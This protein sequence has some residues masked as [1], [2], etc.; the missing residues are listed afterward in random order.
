MTYLNS[1]L[2]STGTTIFS[3]MS[4]L[5][6]EHN[7]VNLSQGFPDFPVDPLL[8]E[9][10]YKASKDGFNQY[11]PMPGIKSLREGISNVIS[12]IYAVYKNPVTEI[13]IT[14][15]ATEALFA[16]VS[17]AVNR[18]DEVIIFD[19]AYDS[20][21]P[22]VI[23]NG[24][25][26][27]RIPLTFP[28]FKM[29][30][31]KILSAVNKKTK[32]II[33]NSPNNPA[34][35]VISQSD[36]LFIKEIVLKNDLYILSDEV[37]EHIVF[38]GLKHHSVLEDD[39]L[40]KRSFA[41]SS[42]GKTFHITGW[43]VGYCVAPEELTSEFRKIHQYLTFSTSTPF[44]IAL[45]QYITDISRIRSLKNFYSEKRDYFRSLLT[46]NG[47]KPF[48][49]EATY[50]QLLDYSGI[51]DEY[52]F[53]FAVSLTKDFGVA[54]IPLSV[55]YKNKT[56]NKVLRFCFAKEN[57]TLEKAVSALGKLV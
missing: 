24:G 13:T 35:T 30:R 46:K 16:A 6:A 25:I 23:L 42:F 39:E 7:A 34:G 53:D 41:V 26:P 29:D 27:V 47:L 3:V 10:V 2:P 48:S 21:E 51:S 22:A 36:F 50:F 52:D 20:Y 14:S 11:A 31:E 32:L 1:K 37:Y 56:D 38:D 9:L 18:G 5:A 15:G 40:F 55:F 57:E 54:S 4:A 45:S 49:S 12:E 33:L 28:D 43:K 44:Q 17:V 19:P 8:Y